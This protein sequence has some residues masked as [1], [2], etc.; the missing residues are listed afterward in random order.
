[1]GQPTAK[2]KPSPSAAQALQIVA[3][4]EFSPLDVP[5]QP[6]EVNLAIDKNPSTA[7]LTDHFLNYANFGNLST[8]AQGSGI[9]VDLGSVQDVS[10]V[11][12]VLP[13]SGQEIEVLAAPASAAS[14]PTGLGG[15]PDR[16]SNPVTTGTTLDSTPLTVPIRTRFVLVHIILLA[17]D[18]SH[19][20]YYH[21]GISEIQV[22]S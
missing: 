21:G 20:T 14:A 12:L 17:A 1:V 4:Q 22:L 5:I 2:P 19:A 8:R 10:S 13:F 18:P 3:A 9:V 6:S 11:N 15:F 16:I 7:W